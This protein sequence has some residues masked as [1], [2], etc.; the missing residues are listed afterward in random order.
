M[1]DPVLRVSTVALSVPLL[2]I[3][4]A[5]Q[6]AAKDK[7]PAQAAQAVQPAPAAT[8]T[9]KASEPPTDRGFVFTFPEGRKLT[10]TGEYRLRA[11]SRLEYDFDK[12]Q[13]ADPNFIEQRIRLGADFEV[14]P[15]V[16][17]FFQ[18]QDFRTWGEEKST[19][20]ASADTFDL[21]QGLLDWRE[22]CGKDT[23]LRFGRQEISLGEQRLVSPLDWASQGR[24]FDGI[25][26]DHKLGERIDLIT[27]AT[28]LRAERS[29]THEEGSWFAG[30][31]LAGKW[32]DCGVEAAV[33]QFV[34][35]DEETA[36]NLMADRW[37]TGGRAKWR[38]AGFD[39]SF[40][41]ALQYGEQDDND[42]PFGDC[43]AL[44]FEVGYTADMDWKPRLAA[45]INFASGND[46]ATPD[47][48]RF[49]N[50]FP[51]AHAYFGYMDFALWENL[52]HFG[53]WLQGR[54]G[55][56]TRVTLAYHWFDAM[57]PGDRFGGPANTLSNGLATGDSHMG[58]EIDTTVRHELGNGLWTEGGVGVFFPGAGV[59]DARGTDDTAL[60]FYVMLG[61]KF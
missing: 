20:D 52:Q 47:N 51:L 26:Y 5:A 58:D 32:P 33:Y 10:L 61:I 44:H 35:Y 60:F 36:A 28:A 37:T 12:D 29:T 13:G 22:P 21:H 2:A 38:K 48:E 16:R 34:L 56:A 1:I 18:F 4:A 54:P 31:E 24:S 11:E 17:V 9:A 15:A 41:G 27:F 45:E 30:L 53:F 25:R 39:V 55:E 42:I 14:N 59:Q 40:E 57:E 7:P 43:Y 49:D 6:E 8:P 50:L 19:V 23:K 3:V 46:P